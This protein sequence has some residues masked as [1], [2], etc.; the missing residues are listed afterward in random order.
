[1][2]E[3]GKNAK[4]ILFAFGILAFLVIIVSFLY[5]NQYTNM[6]FYAS[7]TTGISA[8]DYSG[9]GQ[10]T[11]SIMNTYFG[12]TTVDGGPLVNLKD[13]INYFNLEN[14][15]SNSD[16]DKAVEY[17]GN[18]C[19][20]AYRQLNSVNDLI[21]YLG[22]IS[23]VLFAVMLIFGNSSRRI[24]YKS[25]LIVGIVCPLIAIVFAIVVVVKNSMLISVINGEDS[26]I[27]NMVDYITE[28]RTRSVSLKTAIS[29]GNINSLTIILVDVFLVVFIC[30]SVFIIVYSY[31]RYKNCKEERNEIIKKAV[32]ANE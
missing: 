20:S 15:L 21:L 6:W 10:A 2:K 7:P 27:Y 3:Y 19:M 14:V 5:M 23:L 24:Y 30:Y 8:D 13:F 9:T 17:V 31:L 28:M 25:N 18:I 11:N 22:L 12:Y 26:E 4:P 32:S 16:A 29:S 1:M